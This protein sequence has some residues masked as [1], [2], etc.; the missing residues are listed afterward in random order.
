MNN[1]ILIGRLV[2]EPELRY[3]SGSQMAVCRFT[4]AIDRRVKQGE[5]KKTD[6]PNIICFGKTAENCEKFLAKGRKVAVQGRLQTGSYEKDG[7]KHYTTDVIAD[8]VEFLEWGEKNG[9][10]AKESRSETVPEGFEALD[11]DVPF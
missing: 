11:E 8:N 10:N 2:R 4:L 1:V 5:E 9:E 6:F 3:T 7:V